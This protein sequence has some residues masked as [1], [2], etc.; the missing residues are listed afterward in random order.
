MSHHHNCKDVTCVCVSMCLLALQRSFKALPAQLGQFHSAEYIE[1]LSKVRTGQQQ[2]ACWVHSPDAARC[3]T[4][5]M[6]TDSSSSGVVELIMQK[7]RMLDNA[8]QCAAHRL[9]LSAL[10]GVQCRAVHSTARCHIRP[11]SFS[12]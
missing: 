1:F 3:H 7:P 5:H 12:S 4:S 6:P 11:S 8:T 10:Q 9:L 2:G